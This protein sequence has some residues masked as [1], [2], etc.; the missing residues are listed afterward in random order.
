MRN[1]RT[2]LVLAIFGLGLALGFGCG[3]D[4]TAPQRYTGDMYFV[5]GLLREGEPVSLNNPIRIGKVAQI[6]DTVDLLSMLIPARVYLTDSLTQQTVE[7]TPAPGQIGKYL[8][9]YDSSL[10]FIPKEKQTYTLRIEIEGYDKIITA[11]TTIPAKFEVESNSG[12]TADSSASYPEMKADRIGADF[13]LKMK[14][15]VM[16]GERYVVLYYRSYCLENW[17]DVEYSDSY[18]FKFSDKPEDEEEYEDPSTGYPRKMDVYNTSIPA[19]E[20]RIS[21]K[22]YGS[23]FAFYGRYEMTI[24]S[25]DPNYY[26]YLYKP[27]GFNQGGVVN[28]IGCFGSVS[29]TKLYTRIVK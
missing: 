20:G 26:K 10:S 27:E 19:A 21:D 15:E 7:L 2:L 17:Q 28:G 16:P 8:F 25:I 13:P 3:V 1:Y 24:Y 5:S 11:H 12:F 4:Y 6:G 14:A 22:T 9:F 18:L 23:M 29:G